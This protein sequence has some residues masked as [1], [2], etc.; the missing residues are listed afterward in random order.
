M[1]VEKFTYYID[2]GSGFVKTEIYSNKLNFPKVR[3]KEDIAIIKNEIDGSFVLKGSEFTL[4]DNIAKYADTKDVPFKI[5]ENGD[6]TSGLLIFDGYFNK[7]NDFNYNEKTVIIKEIQENSSLNTLYTLYEKECFVRFSY[8]DYFLLSAYPIYCN[9]SYS[10]KKITSSSFTLTGVINMMLRQYFDSITPPIYC[11]ELDFWFNINTAKFDVSKYRITNLKDIA[12]FGDGE[13]KKLSL[14]RLFEILRVMHKIYWY[15]EDDFKIKFKT[16]YDLDPT[17]MDLSNE[18]KDKQKRV[19]NYGLNIKS[20]GIT[21]NDNNILTQDDKYT[22]SKNKVVYTGIS[23]KSNDYIISEVCTRYTE[24]ATEYNVDGFFFAYCDPITHKMESINQEGISS[25]YDNCKFSPINLIWENYRDY[26]YIDNANYVSSGMQAIAS[27]YHLA[28]FIEVPDVQITLP[29]IYT[30]IDSYISEITSDNRKIILVYDQITDLDTNITILKGF[31]FANTKNEIIIPPPPP[32]PPPITDTLSLSEI[33]LLFDETG[34]DQ[35]ITLTSNTSWTAIASSPD[36]TVT[37]D[38]GSGNT[39]V[40]IAIT[41]SAVQRFANVVFATDEI[42]ASLNIS[43]TVVIVPVDSITVTPGYNEVDRVETQIILT[44]VTVGSWTATK[45]SWMTL[46]ASSGS[47]NSTVTLTIASS[48]IDRTGYAVFTRGTATSSIYIQQRLN[49][50]A[51]DIV[52]ENLGFQY[53]GEVK[54]FDI[55]TT[56]TW[57]AASSQTWC[58]LDDYSGTGNATI[59]VTCS[60]GLVDRTAILTVTNGSYTKYVNIVQ[61]GEPNYITVN[62]TGLS[63]DESGGTQNVVISSNV[64]WTASCA[65][66][67]VSLSTLSGSGNGNIIIIVNS[68]SVAR[69]T[70]VEVT[71]GTI[72]RPIIISQFITVVIPSISVTP[73]Y[74]NVGMGA[75]SIQLTITTTEAWTIDNQN[76]W[77]HFGVSGGTGNDVITMDI[78]YAA[79]PRNG[80]VTFNITGASSGIYI[81]QH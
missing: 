4:I 30:F 51:L 26:M 70:I 76:S 18:L 77:I 10:G 31:E 43:Q 7:F 19:L 28:P 1:I 47:G 55:T 15:I 61:D 65:D 57:Q 58:T 73:G 71:D 49:L 80:T 22:Y 6:S 64:N 41:S 29:S 36:V 40:N 42:T 9:L 33:L 24:E 20:E 11:D 35:D 13:Y 60:A 75:S 37:P 17:R 32:P 25:N 14:K 79:A 48:S 74:N 56:D 67:W 54:S 78:D 45:E 66:G 68:T 34:G 69:D 53:F 72:T 62:P 2:F 38:S 50:V 12:I 5:Y 46:S 44:I 16:V 39:S 23:S 52:P 59:N 21:F 63:Y 8:I 81:S 3:N 27:P